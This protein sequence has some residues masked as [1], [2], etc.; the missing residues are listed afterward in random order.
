MAAKTCKMVMSLLLILAISTVAGAQGMYLDG[1]TYQQPTGWL[2]GTNNQDQC[3]F[4][5]CGP[6]QPRQPRRTPPQENVNTAPLHKA[7]HKTK[8]YDM[9]GGTKHGYATCIE[10]E[11]NYYIVS[12]AHVW[13]YSNKNYI[14]VG[15]AEVRVKII[16]TDLE[17]D[18]CILECPKDLLCMQLSLA[19][20]QANARLGMGYRN[21]FMVK[22]LNGEIRVKGYVKNG[23][24]GGPIFDSNGLVGVIATYEYDKIRP[25]DGVTS[26]PDSATIAT[27]IR[28]LSESPSLPTPDE[29]T[30]DVPCRPHTHV[31]PE[32]VDLTGILDRIS[33][34]EVQIANSDCT[35]LRV[36]I[37]TNKKDILANKKR[38]DELEQVVK[39]NTLGIQRIA[40]AVEITQKEVIQQGKIIGTLE[41]RGKDV[42]L[43]LKRLET[44]STASTESSTQGAQKGKLHFRVRFDQAGRVIGVDPR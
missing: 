14:I 26:G 9:N 37:D 24:S 8:S 17:A 6:R 30:P 27:L 1:S 31:T 20:V 10:F 42:V 36:D 39:N 44:S 12:C 2:F 5:N 43:R 25:R 40:G 33:K 21:G 41:Q 16:K 34:L 38:L 15:G 11:N 4:G 3:R 23:D 18:L 35:G 13:N 19:S 7:I 28:S 29:P 32:P 22:Y